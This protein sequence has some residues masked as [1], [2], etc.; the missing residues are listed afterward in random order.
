[1]GSRCNRRRRDEPETQAEL[2]WL[3]D[4]FDLMIAIAASLVRELLACVVA[5]IRAIIDALR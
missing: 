3:E 4:Y 2:Q 1:M 5:I